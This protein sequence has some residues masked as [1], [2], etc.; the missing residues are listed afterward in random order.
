MPYLG[1]SDN[2]ESKLWDLS[3]VDLRY[4]RSKTTITN[5][6]ILAFYPD[7]KKPIMVTK[8]NRDYNIHFIEFISAFF[9]RRILTV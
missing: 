2:T 5:Y 8:G 6:K 4:I 1:T 9:P 7:S 3:P